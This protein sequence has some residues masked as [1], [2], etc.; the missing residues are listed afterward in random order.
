MRL[1]FHRLVQKDLRGILNYYEDAAGPV[2]ASRFYKEFE[3]LVDSISQYPGRFH[4]VSPILRRANF[5]SFPYHLLF[6]QT[7]SEMR[8]LVLRHHR[9][10]PDYGTQRV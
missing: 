6:H 10:Q 4:S 1:I 2:L 7:E 9:R 8:I 3:Q 5:R